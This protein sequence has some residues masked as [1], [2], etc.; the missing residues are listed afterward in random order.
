MDARIDGSVTRVFGRLK[1]GD[2]GAVQEL[3]ERYFVLLVA[4]ARRRLQHQPRLVVADEEDAVLSAFNSFHR[5]AQ[6][7]DFP[8]IMDRDDLWVK[9]VDLTSQKIIDLRRRQEAGKRDSRRT[10]YNH[11]LS[12][13]VSKEPDPEVVAIWTD[14]IRH[15]LH[16]LADDRLREVAVMRMGGHTAE[17]IADRF[18][19]SIAWV[20]RRLREIRRTWDTP[21]S[22]GAVS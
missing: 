7:G 9:L 17:E 2:P 21:G 12:V 3:W 20:N 14:E 16:Q 18:G 15:R 6:R 11:E 19:M 22:V 13:L 1:N 4:L 5:R 10:E 8:D